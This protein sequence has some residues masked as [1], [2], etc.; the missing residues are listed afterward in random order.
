M[1]RKLGSVAGAPRALGGGRSE[2]DLEPSALGHANA[3]AERRVAGASLVPAG[4]ANEHI[5]DRKG[6]PT[7]VP[8]GLGNKLVM[9]HE[10]AVLG[11]ASG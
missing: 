8:A 3:S 6:A 7:L 4:L 2:A 10:S 11:V 5:V 1:E 9:G